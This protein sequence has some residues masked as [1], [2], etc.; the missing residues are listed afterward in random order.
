MRFQLLIDYS[1]E[2]RMLQQR[3]HQMK[4]TELTFRSEGLLQQIRQVEVI[5]RITFIDSFLKEYVQAELAFQKER[6]NVYR[7]TAQRVNNSIPYWALIQVG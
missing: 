6:E 5:K 2:E 4:M 7:V 3:D 1:A